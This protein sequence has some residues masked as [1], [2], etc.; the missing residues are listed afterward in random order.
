MRSILEVAVALL[1]WGAVLLID[2]ETTYFEFLVIWLL[3]MV[4]FELHEGKE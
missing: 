4:L 1:G 3:V 2:G